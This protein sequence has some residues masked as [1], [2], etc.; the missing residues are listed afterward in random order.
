MALKGD[1][2]GGKRAGAGRKPS[3]MLPEN[4]VKTMLRTA[5]KKA[6]E[7]GK[8]LDDILLELAYQKKDPRTR[9]AAIKL[10][11]DFTMTKHTEKDI[12][13]N[14]NEGPKIGLP[15]MKPDPALV[16]HEGGKK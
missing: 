14:H 5:K 3:Y 7:S 8:T 4:L 10:F 2:R 11:K 9:L 6:K 15:E 16:L 13:V 1:T 12:N